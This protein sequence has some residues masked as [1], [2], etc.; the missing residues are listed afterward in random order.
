MIALALLRDLGSMLDRV[1]K[2]EELSL[3]FRDK[4]HA[5]RVDAVK[6]AIRLQA[7]AGVSG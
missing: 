5:F 4:L 7:Q 3:N 1:L 2:E 6:E